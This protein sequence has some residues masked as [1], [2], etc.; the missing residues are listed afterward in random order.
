MTVNIVRYYKF[1]HQY[2]VELNMKWSLQDIKAVRFISPNLHKNGLLSD[3]MQVY[4]SYYSME[5]ALLSTHVHFYNSASYTYQKNNDDYQK[6]EIRVDDV[7]KIALIG[8]ESGFAKVNAILKHRENDKQ[9]YI[10]IYVAWFKDISRKN[11]LLLC[12]I[13]QLQKTQIIL[14]IGPTQ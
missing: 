1:N 13:Y 10:F 9:D 14:G 8:D 6:M 7:A 11:E 4:S 2:E 3:I 5:Q 12:P